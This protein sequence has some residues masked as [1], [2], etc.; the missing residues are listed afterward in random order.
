[1]PVIPVKA[2]SNLKNEMTIKID[3]CLPMMNKEQKYKCATE[4]KLNRYSIAGYKKIITELVIF[5]Y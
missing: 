1:M 3:L 4:Q 5:H 2:R